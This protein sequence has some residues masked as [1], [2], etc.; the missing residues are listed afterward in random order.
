[1]SPTDILRV[2]SSHF[3][4]F[5]GAIRDFSPVA[6][7]RALLS[8]LLHLRHRAYSQTTLIV[9]PEASYA[10]A[11]TGDAYFSTLPPSAIPTSLHVP[12]PAGGILGPSPNESRPASRAGS[13]RT[14]RSYQSIY[15]D[16]GMRV[17]AR[18][19]SASQR[20][21]G[22]PVPPQWMSVAVASHPRS[23]ASNS[24]APRSLPNSPVCSTQSVDRLPFPSASSPTTPLSLHPPQSLYARQPDLRL[25]TAYMR[26]EVKISGALPSAS[27][28]TSRHDRIT[29]EID[30]IGVQLEPPSQ[31]TSPSSFQLP[32]AIGTTV[33]VRFRADALQ[34]ARMPVES[35]NYPSVDG[36]ASPQLPQ[37]PSGRL[38]V[39]ITPKDLLWY[40]RRATTEKKH[41]YCEILPL[42][43]AF[44]HKVPNDKEPVESL[45]PWIPFTHPEGSLYFLH[46][47]KR[48]WTNTYMYERLY[49]DEVEECV[50]YLEECGLALRDDEVALPVD[51]E[52]VIDIIASGRDDDTLLWHYYYVD[53]SSQ[54][55]FW[56][57][58]HLLWKE[59]EDVRGAF[60][61]DHI[62]HKVQQLYWHHIFHFPEGQ[63]D[64]ARHFGPSVWRKLLGSIDFDWLDGIVSPRSTS[65]F[66]PT[67][68]RQ[69]KKMVQSAYEQ[70]LDGDLIPEQLSAVARIQMVR[71]EQRFINA[72]GQPF[73]RLDNTDSI[74]PEA[75]GRK[76]TWFFRGVNL[77]LLHA[78]SS[79]LR[80]LH[81]VSVDDIILEYAWRSYFKRLLDDWDRLVLQGAVVLTANVSFLAI[82]DVIHFPGQPSGTGGNSAVQPWIRPEYT[83]SASLSYISTLL[84]LGSVMSGLLL[85]RHNRPQIEHTTDAN[86]ASKYLTRRNSYFFGL[87]P[88]AVVYSLP[89]ALMIWGTCFF[90]AAILSFTFDSTDAA[91]RG[92]V[93][94]GAVVVT[95]LLFWSIFSGKLM[96]MDKLW[97]PIANSYAVEYLVDTTLNVSWVM[98]EKKRAIAGK[99]RSIIASMKPNTAGVM[100]RDAES[101]KSQQENEHSV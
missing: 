64:M 1:M 71:A 44:P 56:L 91:T 40:T 37:S 66:S 81:S 48:V 32:S 99:I 11:E 45:G 50:A 24:S 8:A 27:S 34:S 7:L 85:A 25:D 68:L 38:L 35:S 41:R 97:L 73:A 52:L 90:L 36:R 31:P 39:E 92:I 30:T 62:Y 46:P 78:P 4:S 84:S 93:A 67:E 22:R 83:W 55:I 16:E 53:H 51:C 10:Q 94:A 69:M 89:Y 9:P 80:D 76:I 23:R 2:I 77:L 82:P 12:D 13:I 43:T 15:G 63:R 49:H 70:S 19:I 14:V 29:H 6:R 65:F 3:A 58:R 74:Y 28:S 61:P 33:H 21:G 87:E 75:D 100:S 17:R 101:E 88:I 96:L 98:V 59:I 26:D 79:F 54:S 20:E 5:I 95:G 57:R 42:T 47:G 60:S 18:A 86:D 72:H